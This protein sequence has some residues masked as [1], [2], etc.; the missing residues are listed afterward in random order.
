MTTFMWAA[1]FAAVCFSS[2]GLSLACNELYML[3]EEW[4]AKDEQRNDYAE[5]RSPWEF[6]SLP[7]R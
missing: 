7:T 5:W 3:Y 6:P 2:A 4:C 1:G